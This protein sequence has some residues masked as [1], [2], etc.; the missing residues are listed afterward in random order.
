MKCCTAAPIRSRRAGPTG[1]GCARIILPTTLPNRGAVTV[2]PVTLAKYVG[3]YR[4]LWGTVQRTVRIELEG[5]SLYSNGVNG[6]KVRL[7]PHA[8]ASFMG[9]DGYSFDFD[10]QGAPAAFMVERHVSG[11]WKYWRQ[12]EK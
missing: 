5:G 1:A 10:P 4:G 11:D 3:V 9:T 8:D 6:E 2:S 7:I 12:R